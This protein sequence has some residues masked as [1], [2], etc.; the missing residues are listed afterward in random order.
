MIRTIE[1]ILGLPPQNLHD[2]GVRPMTDIF[3]PTKRDW[4]YT[5]A[6]SSLLLGTQLPFELVQPNVRRAD[7]VDPPMP[8][9]DAAWWSERA[10]GFDFSDADRA[11]PALYNRVLWEG[12]MGGKAYPTA[13]SGLDLRHDRDAL[14]KAA[15]V[16]K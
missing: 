10:K 3:D 13:R 9:H 8:L 12:T 14:L 16:I 5:A 7:A 1:E 15:G 11:D 6:P 4:T 2:A